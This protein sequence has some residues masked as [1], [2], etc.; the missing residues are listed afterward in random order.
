VFAQTVTSR[1]RTA[2]CASFLVLAGCGD[3]TIHAGFWFEPVQFQSDRIGGPVTPADLEVIE[4]VARAELAKAFNRLR[5]TFSERRDARYRVRVVQELQD[6]R[7]SRPLGGAGQSR[8]INGFGGSGT[9]SFEFLASGAARFAPPDADRQT[10]IE[11]IGRGI[12]RTAVHEFTH[13]LLPRAPIHDSTNVGSYEYAS[14]ARREQFY[15]GMKWEFA[16]PLL[17]KRVGLSSLLRGD[18]HESSSP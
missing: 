6:P 10:V 4:R 11:G 13:Q 18:T 5:I 14:A 9:V 15:G 1:L 2:I 8:A 12:G 17:E 16:W 3:E 7:F